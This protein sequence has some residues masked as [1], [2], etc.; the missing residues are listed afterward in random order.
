MVE[1]KKG[2]EKKYFQ[3]S[4]INL[5]ETIADKIEEMILDNTLKEGHKFPPETELAEYFGVSRNI[6]REAMR[7]LKERGLIRVHS[8][9]GVFVTRPKGKVL[10][11][12]FTRFIKLTD[13]S[14]KNVYEFRS[15]LEVSVC[16]LAAE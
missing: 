9:K 14:L 13:I 2:M 8:G 11:D 15:A 4:K 16:G 3:I 7:G 10:G 12:T 6:L 1:G 5:S